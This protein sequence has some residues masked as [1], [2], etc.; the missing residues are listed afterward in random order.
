V[1]EIGTLRALGMRRRGI[2]GIFAAEGALLGALGCLIGVVVSVALGTGITASHI[3]YTPPSSS[4]PVPLTIAVLPVTLAVTL[5]LLSLVSM[6]A[7]CWPARRAAHIEIV[8]ALS[9][10]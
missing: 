8:D 4:S 2:V 7:A 9:H 1:R 5:G 10:V 6:L 3:T